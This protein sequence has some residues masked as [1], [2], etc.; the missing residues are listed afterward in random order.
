MRNDIVRR[1]ATIVRATAL[2]VA[3]VVSARPSEAQTCVPSTSET[4]CA[5]Q[6]C[7]FQIVW[8]DAGGAHLER[9]NWARTGRRI[10][11]DTGVSLRI[12]GLNF[13]RY[14][15]N[16]QRPDGERRPPTVLTSLWEST[17]D[18]LQFVSTRNSPT[19]GLL[20]PEERSGLLAWR[21]ELIVI[22]EQI[23]EVL[24]RQ[25]SVTIS[26]ADRVATLAQARRVAASMSSANAARAE[27]RPA[28]LDAPV[29]VLGEFGGLA[30]LHA[31]TAG[32]VEAFQEAARL[33][34]EGA[35]FVL[36]RRERPAVVAVTLQ[37][38]SLASGIELEP[39]TVEYPT[40]SSLPVLFHVGYAISALTD[41]K[42]ETVRSTNGSDLF[43]IVR[44]QDLT[45]GF[46]AFLGY[47]LRTWGLRWPLLAT[48]GTDVSSPGSRFYFGGSVEF[49]RIV[50]TTGLARGIVTSAR[51]PVADPL[52]LAGTSRTLYGTATQ[53]T[54][55]RPF[56]AV[57]LSPY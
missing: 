24:R 3:I 14:Q 48:I 55:W 27:A 11:T 37:P 5:G 9:F 47:D 53:T 45:P 28:L 41:V 1:L 6:A 21:R 51:D 23:D 35:V 17:R 22:N 18:D 50:F 32:R 43:S 26:E 25:D 54:K 49:R 30:N 42:L 2:V 34:C 19:L 39:L 16:F 44:D 40:V 56:F 38:Q 36:P 13:L 8:P 20:Q 31:R 12:V 15:V 4:T 57:S 33:V 46:S 7:T 52:D 29:E 10:T